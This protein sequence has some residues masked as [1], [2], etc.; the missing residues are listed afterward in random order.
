MTIK[1]LKIIYVFQTFSLLLKKN[2]MDLKN[3][4]DDE[5]IELLYILMKQILQPPKK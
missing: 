3:K 4:K 5:Y 1:I 2:V